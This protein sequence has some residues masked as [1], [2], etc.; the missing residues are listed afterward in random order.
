MFVLGFDWV[1]D[2]QTSGWAEEHFLVAIGV[3]YFL[4]MY[5][6][7]LPWLVRERVGISYT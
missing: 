6:D 3:G 2:L 7:D 4:R 1:G 5:K